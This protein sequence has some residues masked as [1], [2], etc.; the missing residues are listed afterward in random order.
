M[1]KP[2]SFTSP[3][4]AFCSVKR[5]TLQVNLPNAAR[6]RL[7]GQMWQ[8]LSCEDQMAAVEPFTPCEVVECEKRSVAVQLDV[9]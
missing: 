7:L 8:S 3:Y 9:T 2:P 6:E 1:C 4:H 5:P